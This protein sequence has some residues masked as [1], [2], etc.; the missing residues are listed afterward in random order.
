MLPRILDQK[1]L[2]GTVASVTYTNAIDIGDYIATLSVQ[3][4][5]DVNTPSAE[6]FAQ[7][8]VS[9]ANDTFPTIGN[10]FPLGLKVRATSTGTLPA[11][12]TTG[13]D[14]FVIPVGTNTISVASS[15]A[16]A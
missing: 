2:T 12:I 6:T 9:T 3:C 16:N 7:D 8:N 1:V 4:F 5:I 13:V 10:T 15:L 11:G 14:Y